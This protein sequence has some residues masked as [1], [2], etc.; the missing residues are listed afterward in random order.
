MIDLVLDNAPQSRYVE[1]ILAHAGLAWRRLDAASLVPP[2]TLSPVLLL[3]GDR[4]LDRETVE[5]VTL[6]VRG[7][8]AVIVTG[9]TWGLDR[10]L[11]ATSSGVAVGHLDAAGS[12][13]P[14]IG[15]L[16]ASL[17]V[18]DA[19]ALRVTSGTSIA[20]IIDPAT[21]AVAADGIVVN[22]AG[23]G[24]TVTIAA[25]IPASVLQIQLGRPIHEDGR[26]APDGTAAID[27]GDLK[28]DDGVVLSWEHDRHRSV[29]AE[30]V[31][32]CPGKDPGF[33][34]GDTPWFAVPVA[35][36]LRALLLRAIHWAAASTGHPLAALTAW[37]RG[38]QA[39]GM[40]SHDSDH[41]V[42]LGARVT[43]DLLARAGIR[44][45]WCHI[46]SPNYSEHYH[47][48]T[49]RLVK[50]AGH[51]IGLHYNA[52]P[53]EGCAWSRDQLAA[54][55]AIVRAEAG[56]DGFVSNKNH[57]LRW[58]G[59]VE[60]FHWLA[61]EG[62]AVDQSK[63]PSKK[64][65]VGYP[66]GSS[67]PW[68][69]L[70]PATG[71]FIDVVEIPLQFQDLW[72]TTPAYMSRTTIEAAIRHHGVAHFLFHQAHL[73]TK[74]DVARAFANVIAEGSDAGLEWWT[75]AEINAW[76][77]L[78]RTVQVRTVPAPDGAIRLVAASRHPVSGATLAV[79]LAAD[80]S[81]PA[82]ATARG[83]AIPVSPGRHANQRAV[84]ITLDLPAGDTT[85]TVG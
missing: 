54:Q 43:L 79:T 33:P 25:N 36:E 29:L 76:E 77:R 80:A 5:A 57:Y 15:D 14:V 37:P 17:H 71:E 42:D 35:D 16:E 18:P 84:F 75:S 67:L 10:L 26:P 62:I 27:D 40:I 70:D 13:H 4:T 20:R 11:G 34:D 8:G 85:I 66:H 28:T 45:T 6:H 78:R 73:H 46:W 63:G 64:G 59:R 58:E 82:S 53:Q 60:F 30:P 69:P 44:S 49:F 31:P 51:E 39:V 48:S 1:E 47:A 21:R 22:H 74:P 9:G 2:R 65:N 52:R 72:L 23:A 83:E 3:A 81:L 12:D 55:S 38:R 41:N 24:V 61:D 19:I 32:E 50:D 7:G 56:V 68:F